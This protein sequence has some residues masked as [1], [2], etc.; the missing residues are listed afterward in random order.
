M[1]DERERTQQDQ[2]PD[3]V[4]KWWTKR[5][6]DSCVLPQ[7]VNAEDMVDAELLAITRSY[8][9]TS[10]VLDILD[11]SNFSGAMW[12]IIVLPIPTAAGAWW[13]LRAFGTHPVEIAILTI[14]AVLGLLVVGSLVLYG[15]LWMVERKRVGQFKR[16]LQRHE[17]RPAAKLISGRSQDDWAHMM[18]FHWDAD[19]LPVFPVANL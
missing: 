6:N 17:V 15:S 16:W 7:G 1:T 12:T 14:C 2:F 9:R 8:R 11:L 13:S 18:L 4:R 10:D 19:V 5:A 3:E